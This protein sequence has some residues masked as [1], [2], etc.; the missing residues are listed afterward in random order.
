M[1]GHLLGGAGGIESVFTVLALHDQVSPPTINIF[2][3]DPECDL[4]YCA[5]AGAA[6]EDR[7]RGQEQLRLRRHQ[8]HARLQAG[9]SARARRRPCA[10]ASYCEVERF[11]ASA[12]GG[13]RSRSWPLPRSRRWP[14]GRW[15]CSTPAPAGAL[16]VLGLAASLAIG[17]SRVR[18]LARPRRAAGVSPAATARWT[19]AARLPAA[20]R[21]G[22]A[23]GGDRSAAHSCCFAPR[24]AAG[25]GRALAAGA[26]ARPASASGMPCAARSYSPPPVA[27]A[28]RGRLRRSRPNERSATPTRRSSSASSK[29]TSR[30]SRCWSSSTSGGSSG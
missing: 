4:D 17:T 14:P 13:A 2:N 8:R 12:S 21:A 22:R 29:A 11:A 15:R 18:S 20:V 24:R 1:T 23:R 26:A 27:G 7:A 28:A 16:V 3:Q 9:L 5:N 25:A 30:P 6:D 10:R 19:L